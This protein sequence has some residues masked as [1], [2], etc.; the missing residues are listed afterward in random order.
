M[1]RRRRHRRGMDGRCFRRRVK[2]LHRIHVRR[3]RSSLLLGETPQSSVPPSTTLPPN[4][5]F[6]NQS[7]AS[8]M[9]R[10]GHASSKS[11]PGRIPIP[12]HHHYMPLLW[13]V[14]VRVHRWHPGRHLPEYPRPTPSFSS[15]LTESSTSLLNSGG[16]SLDGGPRT[17]SATVFR[18]QQ[19]R[20]PS[21]TESGPADTSPLTLRKPSVSP[22]PSTSRKPQMGSGSGLASPVPVPVSKDLP[23]ARLSVVNSD[24]RVSDEEGESGEKFDYIGAYGGEAG[25]VRGMVRGSM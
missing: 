17:I 22:S 21:E 23:R 14:A 6:T 20:S 5:L 3:P 1:R 4:P 10:P 2:L 13:V 16:S 19:M 11:A 7:R 24:P 8:L 25:R 15:P 18:R 9:A 12:T